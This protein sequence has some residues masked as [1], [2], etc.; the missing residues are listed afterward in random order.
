MVGAATIKP[1]TRI[2]AGCMTGTSLDGI[3]VALV[4]IDGRGLGMKATLIS[5]LAE[6]M[7]G[8]LRKTLMHL[9]SGNAAEPITYLRAARRLG[10]FHADALTALL[11]QHPGEQPDFVT[12]HGQTIWHAPHARHGDSDE[13]GPMSWQLFDPWP[14]V[15]RHG[16]PVCYDLRQA[17]LIA[18]GEGAPL[19]PIADWVMYRSSSP[20]TVVN[21]GGICNYTYLGVS[22]IDR[23]RASD[24]FACNILLD[25]LTQRLFPG[26]KFDAE[27]QIAARGDVLPFAEKYLLKDRLAHSE[28]VEGTGRLLVDRR[29][30]LGRETYTPQWVDGFIQSAPPNTTAAD[31]L[32]SAVESIAHRVCRPSPGELILAGG[33]ARNSF[34]L[35]RIQAHAKQAACLNQVLLSDELG[36][37]CE[38][39]EAMGFAVLGAL[40][41]DGV[42]V[43]LPQVTGAV[44]PGV[45]GVWAGLRS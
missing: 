38:A 3:D 7:P 26:K 27:G 28:A 33:G 5:H 12:A 13:L 23:I 18:G 15:E 40:S 41:Q 11:N 34:L 2:V 32:C 14:I 1:S 39:R 45:A 10:R 30:S 42:A 29:K 8:E 17:D 25:G 6:P 22:G 37:P 43:S 31:I 44:R 21:L 9:A 4:R 24:V 20:R 16:V 35:K 36:I 19:T